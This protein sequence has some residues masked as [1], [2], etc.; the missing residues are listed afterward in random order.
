MSEES[1]LQKLIDDIKTILE[2]GGEIN[3]DKIAKMIVSS[4][5]T[6]LESL[7]RIEG[8]D[9]YNQLLRRVAKIIAH[10]WSKRSK[11]I[12]S[13]V[14]SVEQL[15]S[16]KYL[17][18]EERGCILVKVNRIVEL[19]KGLIAYEGGLTCISISKFIL[20]STANY[21]SPIAVTLS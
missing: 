18:S 17:V 6:S 2:S 20:L 12:Q 9:I 15:L 5:T 7:K 11:L 21:I 14:S 8:L 10:I 4:K 1:I 3:L 19:D 13:I 16:G